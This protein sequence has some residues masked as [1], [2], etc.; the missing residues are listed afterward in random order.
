MNLQETRI[1]PLTNRIS[2]EYAIVSMPRTTWYW[3]DDMVQN[4]YPYGGYPLF[5]Q[6]LEAA[7]PDDLTNQLGD[8]AQSYSEQQMVRLYALANDNNRIYAK[9]P[10]NNPSHPCRPA[11]QMRMPSVYQLFKFMP[12]A[13]YLTTIW[14]RRNYHLRDEIL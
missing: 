14:E 13:T 10:K 12:H 3:L 9:T 11:F 2:R 7:T 1:L 6:E 8:W 5:L 4:H